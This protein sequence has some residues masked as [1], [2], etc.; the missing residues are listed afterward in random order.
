MDQANAQT[1][2][3]RVVGIL[4]EFDGPERLKAAAAGV[5][6]AGYT[7][8]EAYS[9]FPIHGIDAAMG[10]RRTCLP[11]LVL[12][13]GIAGGLGA[14]LLQWWTNAIDYPYIISGKPLFSLPANIPITFE[15]IILL[16]ALAAFG[17]GLVLSGLPEWF[18]PLHA[19]ERFRRATTDG[20]FLSIDADDDKFGQT[21][22]AELLRSLGARETEVYEHPETQRK[23]PWIVVATIA[24][25]LALALLPPLLVAKV[26]YT[27]KAR[28]R[29]HPVSDMDAQPKYLPQQ[30][31]EWFDDGRAMRPPVDGAIAVD[32]LLGN[33]HLSK[34]EIDGQPATTFPMPVTERRMQRG[35]QRFDIYCAT[36]HG[37]VGDGDGIT[38]ELALE[39][40]E[41]GWL[42]PLSLHNPSV[43]EQPVGQLLKTISDGVRTMPGYRSQIGVEDRW[44][45]VAYVRALQRA[46]NATLDDV[47]EEKR[48]HLDVTQPDST[49]KDDATEADED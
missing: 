43:R 49:G 48:R 6:E 7:R 40:E 32:V 16:A 8:F 19:R 12:G 1:E 42:R 15:A 17:G 18:H 37:L 11:W 9:P 35:R 28:P 45:I 29:L 13:G 2:S 24:V 30:A 4:A 34:G 33:D 22:T 38:S 39:R 21:E 47:P 3:P 10:R 14:L 20:F 46:R 41:P 25:V 36:C 44:D 5:R 23:L 26:R 27:K 31:S